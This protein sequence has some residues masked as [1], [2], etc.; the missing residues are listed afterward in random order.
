MQQRIESHRQFSLPV[1]K[2]LRCLMLLRCKEPGYHLSVEI[3]TELNA[4]VAELVSVGSE[5]FLAY[6]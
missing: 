1:K 2:Q 5:I 6:S 4:K 3:T